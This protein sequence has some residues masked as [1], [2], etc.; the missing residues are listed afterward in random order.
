[1]LVPPADPDAL[2]DGLRRVLTDPELAA[3][4]GG[5]AR[6]WSRT[7]LPVEVMVDQHV[8]IYRELLEARCAE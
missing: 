3:R 5:K 7:H 2:A 6:E 8:H 4:L 1:V